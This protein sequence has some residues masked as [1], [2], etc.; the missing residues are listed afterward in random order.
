MTSE[1]SSNLST[2]E[3]AGRTAKGIG[4]PW[5]ALLFIVVAWVGLIPVSM[6][7][8]IPACS[9]G[10]IGDGSSSGYEYAIAAGIVH[11]NVVVQS[12]RRL[13]TAGLRVKTAFAIP[14]IVPFDD[15]GWPVRTIGFPLSLLVAAPLGLYVLRLRRSKYA[16]RVGR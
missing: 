15:K 8:A 14:R 6:T 16:N 3:Y 2:L 13:D 10:P 5:R 7:I 1:A 11:D 9:F 4:L 12:C